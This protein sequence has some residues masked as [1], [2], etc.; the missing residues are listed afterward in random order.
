MRL[1]IRVADVLLWLSLATLSASAQQPTGISLTQYTYQ[2]VR[3]PPFNGQLAFYAGDIMS[4]GAGVRLPLTIQVLLGN[5]RRPFAVDTGTMRPR[6][7]DAYVQRLRS[8][9]AVRVTPFQIRGRGERLTFQY[10]SRT[11]TVT[12]VDLVPCR[13]CADRIILTLN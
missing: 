2:T 5:G 12:A 11:F 4:D 3:T 9:G 6:E 8:D 7:F 13:G 10:F 1:P